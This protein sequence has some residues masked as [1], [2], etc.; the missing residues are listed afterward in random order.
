MTDQDVSSRLPPPSEEEQRLANE[1]FQYAHRAATAGNYDLAIQF[2]RQSCKLAPA[3][4]S[5]RQALRKAEK[6]KYKNNQRGSFLAPLTTL[7]DRMRMR[8]AA[9]RGDHLKALEY[10]EA[11]LARNPWD[12]GAHLLAARSASALGL[13]VLAIW[14]LQQAR[15]KYAKDAAVNRALAELLEKEGYFNQAIQLW[16]LVLAAAPTDREAQDK[17]KQLGATETIARGNYAKALAEDPT[18]E[19]DAAADPT[20]TPVPG[21]HK[22]TPVKMPAAKEKSPERRPPEPAKEPTD[23]EHYLHEAASLSRG[24]KFD[25]ARAVLERGLKLGRT[26]ELL[27]ALDHLE[28]EQLKRDRARREEKVRARPDDESARRKLAKVV[29]DLEARELAYYRKRAEHDPADYNHRYELG[30]RLLRAGEVDGA[31]CEFQAVRAEARLRYKALMQLGHCFEARKS[32]PLARRNFEE[33]LRNLPPNDV[34]A[35]KELLLHLARGHAAAG[36]LP[37]AIEVGLDLADLDFAY[38]NVGQLLDEWQGRAGPA[39]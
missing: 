11:I 14:T 15:E 10:G 6:A 12:K 23:P 22:L 39:R 21:L 7:L 2:L 25:E 16:E 19:A 27:F 35:K 3:T 37:R 13:S 38:G 4:L 1:H 28:I 36:E 20:V 30:L 8:G 33:A 34:A 24:G 9:S 18:A 26:A 5:Y 17:V 32:W 29:A 31:I